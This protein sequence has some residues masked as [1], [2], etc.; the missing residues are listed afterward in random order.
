VIIDIIVPSGTINK[1]IK[2]VY[3]IFVV[4][5]L[6]SPIMKFLKSSENISLNYSEYEI[7]ESLLNYIHKKQVEETEN[8]VETELSNEGFANINIKIDFSSKNNEL[9]FNS[10]TVFLE[11]VVIDLDKQHINKYEFIRE[12]VNKHTNL[13]HEVIIFDEW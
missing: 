2:S 7:S 8:N 1:Y 3:S 11:N 4:A 6:L 5:V 12:V 10:C 13:T 9:L